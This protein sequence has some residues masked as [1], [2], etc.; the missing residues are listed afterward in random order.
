MPPA[1]P[2]RQRCALAAGLAAALLLSGRADG[3]PQFA[4][5]TINRYAKLIL[6]GPLQSGGSSSARI[7]YT[8]MVGD[9]PANALRRRADRDGN[10]Q[11]DPTEQQQLAAELQTAVKSALSL[12]LDGQPLVPTWEPPL[13]A[14]GEPRTGPLAFS[15]ELTARFTLPL[16]DGRPHELHYNDPLDLSPVGEVE[17][18]LEEGPGTRIA[19]AWQGATPTP[20]GPLRTSFLTTGPPLSS[21]SDR[22]I[23]LRF[24][25]AGTA[26]P[27]TPLPRPH[28]WPAAWPA[29]LAL[30]LTG[31]LL[32]LAQRRRRGD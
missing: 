17:L 5:A 24:A 11:L 2:H 7:F 18:R 22:S 9:A 13:L 1:K 27:T 19:A 3:H 25:A 23:H 12:T 28:R 20:P 10:G 14:L 32:L 6:G 15:C 26:T 31:L 16:A 4:L 30:L 21:L 8:V 29:G